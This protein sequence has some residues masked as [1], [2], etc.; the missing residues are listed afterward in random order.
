MRKPL[1]L[2][3]VAAAALA[4]GGVTATALAQASPD[5]PEVPDVQLYRETTLPDPDDAAFAEP[6]ARAGIWVGEPDPDPMS[7]APAK[8]K[9]A[10][11]ES[12]KNQDKKEIK[13]QPQPEAPALDIFSAARQAVTARDISNSPAA[14]V[15]QQVLALV[16]KN[17]RA[18]GCDALTP[19]RRL[20]EAANEHAADMAK[21]GY[22]AHEDRQGERAGSRVA[23][24][25]YEWKRYGENIA[26]GQKSPFEVVSDW[27]ESPAH[28]E[29]ILDCRLDQMGVGFAIAGDDTPYWVQDFAT[30]R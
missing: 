10:E 21:R 11:A 13:R 29:N 7:K 18:H 15:Q 6:S 1:V 20:I 24:A 14:P 23:G 9:T 3:C 4:A 8:E 30:P 2:A 22:F 16:N 25:G 26:R 5:V 28:R 19:D 27:M 12:P 17:R